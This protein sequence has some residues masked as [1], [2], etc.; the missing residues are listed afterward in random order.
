[1][2]ER[3]KSINKCVHNIPDGDKSFGEKRKQGERGAVLH[4]AVR[5][6]LSRE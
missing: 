5:G 6:G 2:E 1:M 4:L 3:D